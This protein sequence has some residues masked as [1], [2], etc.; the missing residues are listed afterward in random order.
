MTALELHV[1]LD[2]VVVDAI[3][4]STRLSTEPEEQHHD[5]HDRADD[6]GR[7]TRSSQVVWRNTDHHGPP[8]ADSGTGGA[9]DGLRRLTNEKRSATATIENSAPHLSHRGRSSRATGA[10]GGR[11]V[12]RRGWHVRGTHQLRLDPHT[13]ARSPS[14][15]EGDGGSTAIASSS[16][17]P[18]D[19]PSGA[20]GRAHDRRTAE[21]PYFSASLT[22]PSP[23][24]DSATRPFP[25]SAAVC[26][27]VADDLTAR[28]SRSSPTTRRQAHRRP[29]RGS[30]RPT[31]R[32]SGSAPAHVSPSAKSASWMPFGTISTDAEGELH[33][34]LGRATAV[35]LS[36][37]GS[38]A[39]ATAAQRLVLGR[40]PRWPDRSA[41]PRHGRAHQR[42]VTRPRRGER[43]VR[44]DTS[45][46]KLRITSACAA[47]NGRHRRRSAPPSR[48]SGTRCSAR[49]S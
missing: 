33:D 44:S 25:R 1:D 8:C 24:S 42:R 26:R 39:P 29:F 46:P 5:Q 45:G 28:W 36:R 17:S 16:T 30:C 18:N 27:A 19:S 22:R 38:A 13:V 48:C 34:A 43:L 37:V 6:D 23:Y 15:S 35:R 20:T 14:I 9:G 21:R 40:A 4:V 12:P 11:A 10:S 32:M 41:D 7:T 49:R 3:G 31:N 2:H 47:V